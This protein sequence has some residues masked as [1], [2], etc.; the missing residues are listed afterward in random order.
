MSSTDDIGI[1][2]NC[3]ESALNALTVLNSY[4]IGGFGL[5]EVMIAFAML[6]IGVPLLLRLLGYSPGDD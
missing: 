1:V 3:I 5:L 4:K 2:T 6:M